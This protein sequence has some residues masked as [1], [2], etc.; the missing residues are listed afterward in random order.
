MSNR[1]SLRALLTLN[2]FALKASSSA[3]SLDVT[4]K[5][6]YTYKP[7][8]DLFRVRPNSPD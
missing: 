5:A 3:V 6:A 8:R 2:E 1:D 7:I 4:L